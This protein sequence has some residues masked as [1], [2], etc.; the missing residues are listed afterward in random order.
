MA[1]LLSTYNPHVSWGHVIFGD[2]NAVGLNPVPR[3]MGDPTFL[4]TFPWVGDEG[5]LCV[6]LLGTQD[7]T[8]LCPV[9]QFC[10]GTLLLASWARDLCSYIGPTFGFVLCCHLE[11]DF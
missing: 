1:I 2:L 6:C 8:F 7:S 3:A 10:L 5:C 11:L 4:G 9:S